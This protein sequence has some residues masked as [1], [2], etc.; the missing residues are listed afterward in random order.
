M[1]GKKPS[2]CGKGGHFGE[3]CL[4]ENTI[5]KSEVRC[6]S[7]CMILTVNKKAFLQLLPKIEPKLDFRSI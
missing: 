1:I 2:Y 4:T 6:E 7:D 3:K 5:S